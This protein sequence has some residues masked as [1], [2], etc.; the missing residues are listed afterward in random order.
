MTLVL[1]GGAA[2]AY[3]AFKPVEDKASVVC[4]SGADLG[5][6]R[7]DGTTVA[8]ASKMPAG[9]SSSESGTAAIDDPVAACAQAWQDGLLDRDGATAAQS[10]AAA[11]NQVP[12]LVACTLEE[13]VAGVFP[14]DP[15]TCE[16]L[17]LPQTAR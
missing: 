13:G 6:E 8:V 5:S 10:G 2:T 4:Y 12:K 7:V 16:R 1:A 15:L 9:A 3:V 11:R 17:G 14:G